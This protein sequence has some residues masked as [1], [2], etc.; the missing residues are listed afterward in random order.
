M[1][2]CIL[3]MLST[4]AKLGRECGFLYLFTDSDE[5]A[6]RINGECNSGGLAKKVWQIAV[7]RCGMRQ[8]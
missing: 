7:E 8:M 1:G 3:R 4:Q 5:D 2:A 6:R